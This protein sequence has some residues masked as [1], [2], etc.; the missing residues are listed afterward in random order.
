[1]QTLPIAQFPEIT[2]PVVQIEADYPGAN[3][4]VVADSVAR[5]I[6]VQLP[7]IDNLLY[8][9]STSTND[10][11]MTI[12]LTFEIGTDVDIAQVQTQNREK[13]AEPQ[14]PNEVIRQGISV[15]KVS[16]DL[17]TV[18]ALSS[19]DPRFDML[20]LSNYA[21]INVL[22]N[23]KRLL[24]VGDALTF[25]SAGAHALHT[26]KRIQREM[27]EL[28]KS[29]PPGVKYD[30]P[31]DTTRFIEV[32]IHEVALTL[33]IAMILVILVVYVFL[34]SWRTTLIPAVA[35]PVSLIG[36]LAGMQALGFSI[37]TLT[38]FGMVLAIGIVVDDAIVVVENVERHMKE[39]CCSSK[40][41]A[42][43]A[44]AEVTAPIIAIV[45]VLCAVFVPVGFLGGITGQLY[46]Q[47]AITIAISV[48]ISGFVALTLSPA[49]CA[50]VL[51]PG[52]E[53]VQRKGFFPLFNK[54]FDW[55]RDRYTAV[56]AQVIKRA[57][58]AL[59]VFGV[60]IALGT[61][62]LRVIPSS[63]LPEEDQ[64]YLI[65]VVQL[66]DGASLQR[67]TEV[68]SKLEK[69]F[70]SIPVI[71][72]TDAL[73][74]QNFVFNTRGP[75][76]A[77]LFTPLHLWD[78]RKRPDQHV[79]AIIGGAFREFARIP[80]AFILAFNAPS[81]RGLGATGGFSVQIQDPS[82]GDFKKFS[83][84][85]EEFIAKARQDPAIG[86][87]GTNFRV[88][89]PR[90][91]AH[92]NRERAK[93]LGVPISDVFDTLQAYFGNFYVND[94]LK[95]GRVY[96]VQTEAD[97]QYRMSPSD[98]TKIYVRAQNG[99]GTYMIPL[100]TVVTT[101]FTSG[102]DPVT[103]FNGFN[104]AFVLGAAAPGASSGQALD[105]VERAAK[106][107]LIPKGYGIDWSG[108]SYQ[109]RN[110][111]G[112]SVAA[113]AFGLLMVFLVL[114][115][116]Y[117]SWTVPFAVILAVPFGVFGALSAV[118]LRGMT[119]D[120]FFQIGLV[121]LIGL[122]AKNA[123]LLVDFANHRYHA[124]MSA[125]EAAI[126]AAKIRFRPII[127]T[128]MAFILGV[129]PLVFA[130]G[131]GAA[132]RQSIG[133]GVFGGML[134]ATFLAIFFVPLFFV[135]VLKLVQ[136][137]PSQTATSPGAAPAVASPAEGGH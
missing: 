107:V 114:A 119:N 120:I 135:L 105:A 95:F 134:A 110:V 51:K 137:R 26:P 121:T 124:G 63:F 100:N 16:P 132:G 136:R 48:T 76:S 44:M 126:E 9:D 8:Y 129:T 66:P 106:E 112:K 29:L 10:G 79:K 77:T 11:H 53:A 68:M 36:A 52:G 50:L 30:I 60:V 70:L 82:G 38:L 75:N 24:A 14:I 23:I 71:H 85:A 18:V 27:D 58:L 133:T 13:L 34:Q 40:E 65:T 94:F 116:Q 109:E 101:E 83:A 96:R 125:T 117:E 122:S 97:A 99:Q 64:G 25:L 31:Y 103:H 5:T 78:K 55:T 61:T 86:A 90:L 88:S 32:S 33:G 81:I 39:E 4:E 67:T 130:T 22:A 47:F 111:G 6:E 69:Y 59:A 12:R 43:R 20:Y 41:A 19:S 128:S 80:E 118:W 87:I 115:A 113:F 45:L 7:G 54:L 127:M 131:A 102:P 3:A 17:L 21:I 91:Y 15:K 74:G 57:S 108:I 62:L 93:A 92:V 28:A 98:L 84:V 42:K 72:S 35:V 1:M 123:I 56:A 89:S 2:P 73:V 104:T 46:K 49:L 37:N